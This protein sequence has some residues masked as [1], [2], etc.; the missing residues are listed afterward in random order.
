MFFNMFGPKLTAYIVNPTSVSLPER[1]VGPTDNGVGTRIPAE[2]MNTHSLV[3]RNDGLSAATNVV[4]KH[5]GKIPQ[6]CA[7]PP[8]APFTESSDGS[9]RFDNIPSGE[10][11]VIGYVYPAA[12][13]MTAH[14]IHF[15]A[16]GYKSVSYDGGRVHMMDGVEKLAQ[17]TWRRW[18]FLPGVLATLIA[19]HFV[20]WIVHTL[21]TGLLQKL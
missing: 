8:Y 4:V 12:P 15:G 14:I 7:Y 10:C 19:G 1:V 6:G 16:H 9:A 18:Y 5:C 3:I 17:P 2:I 13:H 21:L 11:V 20:W